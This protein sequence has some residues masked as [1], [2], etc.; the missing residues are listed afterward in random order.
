MKNS[1]FSEKRKDR[2][3]STGFAVS[4]V[5]IVSFSGILVSQDIKPAIRLLQEEQL[6]SA[7][8]YLED[9]SVKYP[10]DAVVSYYLGVAYLRSH[11][12]DSAELAFRKGLELNPSEPLNYA[13]LGGIDLIHGN[14]ENAVK[15]FE[16]VKKLAVK[17]ISPLLEVVNACKNDTILDSFNSEKFIG[18]A[19]D[20]NSK[21][22]NLHIVSG[23]YYVVGR[24]YGKAANAYERAIY[25]DP[26]SYIAYVKLGRIYGEA[27]NY[28]E[29]LKALLN[30]IK[31]DSNG[32]LVYRYLGD[33][34]YTY[35][36]Y[37]EAKFSYEKYLERGEITSAIEERYAY[38]LFFSKNYEECDTALDKLIAMNPDN[39]VLYRLK[40][41]VSFETE[42][43][44]EGL[45]YI[46]KFFRVQDTGKIIATDYIYYGRLLI[47]N[48]QDSLGLIELVKAAEM[49]SL[50]TETFEE[51]AKQYSKLKQ[52]E[53]A[54]YWFKRLLEVKAEN[55]ENT[56]YQVGREYYMWAQDTITVT[57]SIERIAIYS[58][59][60]TAFTKLIEFKPDS[61]LGY[62]FR[63]RSRARLD[64]ETTTGLAKED[65][66]KALSVLETGDT[67]K[68]KN[69]LIEC[70][71]YLAFYFY[72]LNEKG[73]KANE[74]TGISNI[75]SSLIYWRK[76]LA[77]EPTDVQALTAIDNLEKMK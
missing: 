50:K 59:A 33:L 61:Y 45:Q 39:P 47:R 26:N 69:Y 52:H 4:L 25:Y 70:Y 36:Q 73:I 5:F 58:Q 32:L 40:A 21:D 62:L 17:K 55:V 11:L 56:W 66:E 72:M 37:N 68:N 6:N 31:I 35:G 23:D 13:G 57:D 38:I 14:K 67:L 18:L 1:L 2:G 15:N 51:I 77:L 54:V 75:E 74:Q 34:Y 27:K 10:L 3:R 12:P 65:Y 19:G 60:D 24:D 71:R 20:I 9:L 64:P 46:D 49:D 76:I 16:K 48:Q 43:Y 53:P 44:P 8:S 7:K 41:Y 42:K 29:S 30:A 22:P 63:A 28:G